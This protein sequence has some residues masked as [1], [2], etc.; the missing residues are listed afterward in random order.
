MKILGIDTSSRFLCLGFYDGNKTY[1][2]SLDLGKQ[3]SSLI[4]PNLRR[5][6][7]ALGWKFSDIDYFACGLGPGSFTGLRIGLST[8]KGLS[9]ALKKPVVGVSTLD[10]LARNAPESDK[11]II[12]IIDAKRN[13]VYASIYKT[14]KGRLE[15]IAP[16][17]LLNQEALLKKIK[18]NSVALGD[19]LPLYKDKIIMSAKGVTFLDKD[20]WYPKAHNLLE[21]ALAEIKK[22]KITDSFAVKPIYLYPKECQIRKTVDRGQ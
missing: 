2:F 10:I 16:Y 3:M 7:Q 5:A 18:H 13:L 8:V 6:V 20:C 1:G 9:W 12:P 15:R 4:L 14:R 11:Y 17:M 21:L 22:G 19:G